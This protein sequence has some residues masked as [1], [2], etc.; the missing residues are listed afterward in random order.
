M[1]GARILITEDE[2]IVA[3]EIEETLKKLGYIVVGKVTSG[4]EAIL[5][6]ENSLRIW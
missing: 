4:E 3:L 1:A 6:L 2:L 5:R